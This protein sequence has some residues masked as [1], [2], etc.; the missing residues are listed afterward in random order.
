MKKLH[1]KV[2]EAVITIIQSQPD[3]SEPQTPPIYSGPTYEGAISFS[4]LTD[5]TVTINWEADAD[6]FLLDLDVP[7]T[8]NIFKVTGFDLKS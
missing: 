6:A 8:F 7:I 3:N 4:S 1:T 5:S 2:K